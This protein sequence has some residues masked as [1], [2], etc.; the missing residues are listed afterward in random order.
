M[1]VPHIL[2]KKTPH[3]GDGPQPPLSPGWIYTKLFGLGSGPHGLLPPHTEK[4]P[5]GGDG[6]LP[7]RRKGLLP[8][9]P[10]H[11]APVAGVTPPGPVTGSSPM[12]TSLGAWQREGHF[13]TSQG[14]LLTRQV[15]GF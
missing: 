2:E 4:G 9:S 6:F 3:S 15:A 5:R 13:H 14:S 7:W 10:Y 8:P 1:S 11:S 12:S